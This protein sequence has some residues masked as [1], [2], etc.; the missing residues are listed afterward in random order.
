MHFMYTTAIQ[1]LHPGT[2]QFKSLQLQASRVTSSNRQHYSQGWPVL[3]TH[4]KGSLTSRV[5]V[6]YCLS[7]QRVLQLLAALLRGVYMAMA[8]NM[9]SSIRQSNLSL[10]WNT[11]LAQCDYKKHIIMHLT[12]LTSMHAWCARQVMTATRA[13]GVH[14]QVVATCIAGE[15]SKQVMLQWSV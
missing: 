13:K 9:Q 4:C 6:I 11:T 7:C 15:V 10:A 12:V 8:G 3:R 5:L 2:P 14:T 1:S